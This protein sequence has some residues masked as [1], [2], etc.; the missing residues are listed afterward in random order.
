MFLNLLK[1]SF[2]ITAIAS[3]L[4]R[5]SGI[6]IFLLL[7][8]LL[9]ALQLTVSSEQSFQSLQKFLSINW[10][11]FTL[12]GSLSAICYH[13]LAGIRHILMDIGLGESKCMA[14]ISAAI[15]ILFSI[16]LAVLIGYK[17]C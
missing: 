17:L 7:P 12:W 1:I 4:H 16:L 15:T 9:Y 3:I 11:K 14:K 2:P 5:L 13:L 10:V 6:L 8:F